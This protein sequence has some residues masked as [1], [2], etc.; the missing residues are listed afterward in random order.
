[1]SKSYND[2]LEF[3]DGVEY[4]CNICNSIHA[5]GAKNCSHTN[6]DSTTPSTT[7][8]IQ[9]AQQLT[10][11]F[12]NEGTKHDSEKIRLELLPIEA[13]EEISKVLGKGAI[14]Y[15]DWNWAKG[16]AWLRLVGACLRHLFAFIRGENND[17]ETGL[18]H[19]AHAGCCILFLL[20][21]VLKGL[22]KD[23]RHVYTRINS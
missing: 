3:L 4:F 21:Y 12:N 7:D 23:D 1:M 11:I 10:A 15:D 13:L 19:L 2:N 14:K 17:P 8:N 9:Y 5:F 22:G 18:S 6:I 20:T 16:M